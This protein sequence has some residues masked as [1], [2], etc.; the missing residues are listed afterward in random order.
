MPLPDK[1]YFG[2]RTDTEFGITYGEVRMVT[3]EQEKLILLKRRFDALLIGQINELTLFNEEGKRR[4]YS[5]FPLTI[6]TFVAIETIGRVISDWEK[7]KKESENDQV[8]NIVTPI[9]QMM[10]I[11]LSYKPT[12]KFYEAFEALHGFEDKKSIRKYSDVIH[13]YQRNTFTHGYQSKGVYLTEQIEEAIL[14]QESE[15]CLYI[16]PFSF[17]ELFKKTY[18]EVF[19]SILKKSN[20]DWRSNA[21]NYFHN[22]L[23]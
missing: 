9:Y 22:L 21:L 8:K 15:G 3:E 5:P 13:K 2:N 1:T 16:N 17:W 12:K 6:L 11:N 4:V 7:I 19:E 14:I 23:A 10:D 20:K 18:T